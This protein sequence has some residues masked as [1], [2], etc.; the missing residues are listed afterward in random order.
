[1]LTLQL[2]A[3]SLQRLFHIM[4]S[5]TA[6]YLVVSLLKVSSVRVGDTGWR[7]SAGTAAARV[8]APAGR[9]EDA[10]PVSLLRSPGRVK[11]PAAVCC[12][13]SIPKFVAST[14]GRGDESPAQ[15][16]QRCLWEPRSAPRSSSASRRPCGLPGSWTTAFCFLLRATLSPHAC[17]HNSAQYRGV[18]IWPRKWA[19]LLFIQKNSRAS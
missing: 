18:G 4:G 17:L 8:V 19:S 15:R 16:W 1:M 14:A 10:A 13:H 5:S 7:L 9:R 2:G 12:G 11:P 6:L 3:V